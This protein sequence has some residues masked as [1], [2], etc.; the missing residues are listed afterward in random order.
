MCYFRRGG[1]PQGFAELKDETE[2]V[3]GEGIYL[4]EEGPNVIIRTGNNEGGNRVAEWAFYELPGNC[5]V[6]V[7]S[8]VWINERY[9]GIGLNEVLNKMRQ[10][11]A[12]LANYGGLL[13]TTIADY[14]TPPTDGG[15]KRSRPENA[16]LRSRGFKNFKPLRNPNSGNRIQV[17]FK[18]LTEGEL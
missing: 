10:R 8:S 4:D 13:A 14:Q 6:A 9:R 5:G 3:L 18:D 1:I 12:R 7:S 11:M 17:W 15:E 16:T 2:E